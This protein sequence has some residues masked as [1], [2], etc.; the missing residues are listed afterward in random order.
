MAIKHKLIVVLLTVCLSGCSVLGKINPLGGG[1][2]NANAQVGAENTQQVVANQEE[3]NNEVAGDQT[4]N[5]VGSS[6][7]ASEI[8][9]ISNTNTSWW[10]IVLLIIGW[11]LPTPQRMWQAWRNRRQDTKTQ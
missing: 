3:T 8:G 11:V 7:T 2:V 6:V 9:R 4:N 10:I 5:E 1:G